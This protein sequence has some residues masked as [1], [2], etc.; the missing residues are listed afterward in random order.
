MA[1]YTGNNSGSKAGKASLGNQLGHKHS[2]FVQIMWPSV[3]RTP[4][5]AADE[6]PANR[7]GR[8]E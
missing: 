7:G 2:R 3:L 8:T 1:F 5:W 6:R 4:T